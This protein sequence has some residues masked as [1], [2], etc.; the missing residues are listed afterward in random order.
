MGDRLSEANALNLLGQNH[1]DQSD[2]SA[3]TESFQQALMLYQS[4]GNRRGEVSALAN[5]GQT[6]EQD[7]DLGQALDWFQQ[8]L[9][10]AET[11]GDRA[12]IAKLFSALGRLE[13]EQG[14]VDEA[15]DHYQE[16]V[17]VRDAMLRR[18]SSLSPTQQTVFIEKVS[19]DYY[20]LA[21]LLRTRDRHAEA[22]AV[23]EKLH[24]H[25]PQ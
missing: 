20:A 5:L 21:D 14:N 13:R 6:A 2:P 25:S 16:A 24:D 7:G 9:P 8:A 3:A 18:L 10:L 12:T 1:R 11:I 23:L 19:P 17:A 22:E 15:I 4:L